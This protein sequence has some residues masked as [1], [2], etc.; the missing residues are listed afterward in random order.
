MFR[1][2]HLT[3]A[4]LK[5]ITP[6]N[7]SVSTMT[8]CGKL[9]K[10]IEISHV[11]EWMTNHE[12]DES[13]DLTIPPESP[14]KKARSFY[15]QLTIKSKSTSIKLFSNGA[16]HVTGVKSP[17][18]FIDVMDRVS[19]GLGIILNELPPCLESVSF[20]MIN[21]IFCAACTLPLRVL[22][23]SLEDAGHAASYDP[24]AYPGINAKISSG[25]ADVTVMIFT[26]GNVI[27]SGAK[28]PENVSFVY[29][30]VCRLIDGLNL[31]PAQTNA[32]PQCSP[33]ILDMYNIVDG[34]SS[35]IA[36]LCIEG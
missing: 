13:L 17:V 2:V 31:N 3:N 4:S 35:R 24:D 6:R 25:N 27:I 9:A 23:Q 29:N 11:L 15:N 7:C 32:L 26:T 19:N 22:R 18:H 12:L 30:I 21:A 8:L 16:I 5:V 10:E 33:G 14:K 28:S 34:Y 36:H 1:N 20:S